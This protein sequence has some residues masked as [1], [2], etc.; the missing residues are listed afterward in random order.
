MKKI[1]IIY[2][3][4]QKGIQQKALETLTRELLDYTLEYPTCIAADA[5]ADLTQFGQLIYVGTK[6]NNPY[7]AKKEKHP[8]A[9]EGYLITVK[10]GVIYIEGTDDA[11]VLY[12]CVDFYAKYKIG[13]AHV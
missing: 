4:S 8:T 12:G 1:A 6:E 9:K 11:G 3:G 10:D 2:G 7:L 5:A 13:R